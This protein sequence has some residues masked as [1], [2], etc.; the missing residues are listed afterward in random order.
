M[1]STS[2]V[3]FTNKAKCRDCYRCVRVCPVNAIKMENSQANVI[4]ERCINCGTCINECPQNAK[5]YRKSIER[6]LSYIDNREMLVASIAPSFASV[7]PEEIHKRLPS[8]MRQLGFSHISETAVGAY[9]IAVRSKEYIEKKTN[10]NHLLTACPAVVNYVEKYK[11]DYLS[12]LTPVVSPMI[13]HGKLLKKEFPKAKVVFIGP[14]VA[15]KEE[16]ERKEF[17]GIIDLVL[18]FEEFNEILERKN[19]KPELSETSAFDKVPGGYSRLFPLEGGLLKTAGMETN[20]LD[21]KVLAVSGYHELEDALNTI[22]NSDKNYIIEPL[23]CKHG[24][25]NGPAKGSEKYNFEHREHIISYSDNNEGDVEASIKM[26][27]DLK[28]HFYS[29]QAKN[30]KTFTENEIR[31]ILR[32]TGKNTPENELNCTACGYY[33]CREKAIAVLK[34]IAE[35]EMCMPYMRRKAEQKT[36]AIIQSDPNGIVVL[37]RNLNIQSMNKAFKSMFSCSNAILDKHI[38]YLVD[39]VPFENLLQSNSEPVNQIV[40]YSNYNIACHLVAYK[41]PDQEQYVGVFVDITDVQYNKKRINEIKADTI[42][43]AQ[44]LIDHQVN[45]AQEIA[46][47]LGENSAKGEMLMQRLIK[48]IDDNNKL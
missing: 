12:I 36:D 15:K 33:T 31:E 1:I 4:A 3:V 19:I 9:Q 30:E 26:E 29:R 41:I 14:C 37:D 42:L 39:P 34:G 48:A 8:V 10:N 25:I 17:D 5:T 7:Y 23:F 21:A 24:C 13:A 32:K 16:A 20:I 46:K 44:E 35:P 11:T 47:F 40:N 38:S 45:M 2:S 6:L 18:T 22:S 43:Q 27:N 28:T